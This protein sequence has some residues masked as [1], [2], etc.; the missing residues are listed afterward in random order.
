MIVQEPRT[1]RQ[2]AGATAQA[3]LYPQ[4]LTLTLLGIDHACLSVLGPLPPHRTIR[5]RNAVADLLLVV[6]NT[7]MNSAMAVYA[8]SCVM[9][10]PGQISEL[11]GEWILVGQAKV[12][13]DALYFGIKPRSCLMRHCIARAREHNATRRFL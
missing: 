9:T 6:A 13:A 4:L 11:H 1:I 10:V 12:P 3:D 7:V 5:M 2:Q 8:G